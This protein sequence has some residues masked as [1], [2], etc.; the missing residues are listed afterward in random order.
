MSFFANG[1]Q[2]IITPGSTTPVA[3]SPSTATMLAELDFNGT[4]A[5]VRAGGQSVGVT[6]IVGCP[7]TVAVFLLEQVTST[8]LDFSTNGVVRIPVSIQQAASAQ[9]FTKHE[10]RPGDRLRARLNSSTPSAHAAI[11]AEYLA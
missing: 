1:H 3:A 7:S 4:N 11:Q 8:G 9:F 10:I 2:S 5:T 6:W